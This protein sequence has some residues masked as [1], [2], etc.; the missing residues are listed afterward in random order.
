MS[1]LSFCEKEVGQ[2]WGLLIIRGTTCSGPFMQ[3]PVP[4]Q[5]LAEGAASAEK[6][7]SV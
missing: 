3:G 2:M 6:N 7:E 5:H 1:A 4:R